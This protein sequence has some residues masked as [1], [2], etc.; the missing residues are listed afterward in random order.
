MVAHELDPLLGTLRMCCM[1]EISSFEESETKRSIAGLESFL[2]ALRG[3][4]KASGV[5]SVSDFSLNDVVFDSIETVL[6]ER[7][8][9]AAEEIKV[10]AARKDYVGT[11][12]D[13]DL[14]R[15]ALVNILRNALEA[16]DSTSGGQGLPVV[17]NW[18]FTE[19]D[20]WV[21]V[22]DEGVGL[23][24]G[25]SGMVKPGVTNKDKGAHSGMGLPVCIR[26]LKGLNGAL[27]LRPREGGGVVAEMRWKGDEGK[28]AGASN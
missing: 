21:S 18:G 4:Y 17:V 9:N 6:E 7:R 14:V 13:P 25:A 10:E 2:K 11:L 22:L 5:P 16:S 23:P 15:L 28:N 12:G 20:A 27:A 8:Q 19:R 26:A 24:P 1:K 3:L